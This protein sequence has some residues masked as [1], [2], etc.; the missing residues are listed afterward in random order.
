MTKPVIGI[1][2][3]EVQ[4]K[5]FSWHPTYYGQC[6]NYTDAIIRAGGIPVVIPQTNN[7]RVF[8]DLIAKLDGLVL[9]GGADINPTLYGEKPYATTDRGTDKRDKVELYLLEKFLQTDKPILAICRGMHL[10]NVHY[11][12]T[13]YQDIPLDLTTTINHKKSTHAQDSSLVVH[14]IRVK[15]DSRLAEILGQK[16]V[17]VNSRHHQAIKKLASS[18]EP[19]AWAEDKIIEA[20]EIKDGRFILGIQ[21]HPE[22]LEAKTITQW[23]KIFKSFVHASQ[24]NSLVYTK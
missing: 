22:D 13:L 15:P 4:N 5:K 20:V 2:A 17:Y 12:G 6:H 10:L 9:A 3:D 11:G 21:A 1:T 16:S 23:R 7:P 18:L 14:P 19:T 24:E 8:K